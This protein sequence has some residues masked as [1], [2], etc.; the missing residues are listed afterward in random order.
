[1]RLI[2]MSKTAIQRGSKL[3][4]CTPLSLLSCVVE[5]GQLGLEPDGVLGEI[6]LVPFKGVATIIVGYKGFMKLAYQTGTIYSV[7]THIVRPKDEFDVIYGTEE[8]LHH[9]PKGRIEQD[10]DDS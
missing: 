4:E 8:N 9:I 6:Y 10:E 1:E 2:R 7:T 5:C 3:N